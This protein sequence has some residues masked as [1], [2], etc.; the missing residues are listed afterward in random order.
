[1]PGNGRTTRS[2]RLERGWQMWRRAFSSRRRLDQVEKMSGIDFAAN[3]GAPRSCN[4]MKNGPDDGSELVLRFDAEQ[5]KA[6]FKPPLTPEL[7]Q[8]I[9][10]AMVE[11]AKQSAA[12]NDLIKEL[13]FLASR[14]GR[15]LA[16]EATRQP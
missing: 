3:A 14:H 5:V 1:M 13:L 7:Q 2:L 10:A 6:V 9:R 8:E 4:V 16:I 15:T 12:L 11:A